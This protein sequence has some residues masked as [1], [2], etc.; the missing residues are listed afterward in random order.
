MKWTILALAVT[1]AISSEVLPS[2]VREGSSSRLIAE[3]FT[4]T[5]RS[6][7]SEARASWTLSD[8]VLQVDQNKLLVSL[9][10]P[11]GTRRVFFYMNLNKRF[12]RFGRARY[13]FALTCNA[14]KFCQGRGGP[15][16]QEGN[17]VYYGMKVVIRNRPLQQFIGRTWAPFLLS[18]TTTT[19]PTETPV[20][21][22]SAVL[23]TAPNGC[24]EVA[25]NTSYGYPTLGSGRRNP[26]R[27]FYIHTES[28]AS[29]WSPVVQELLDQWVGQGITLI[30]R[31]C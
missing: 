26:E 13:Q 20:L 18:T 28:K 19:R 16:L 9:Q 23:S 5:R 7:G 2:K 21:S 11:P 17:V 1:L 30:S 25:Y 10:G 15:V 3:D 31:S 27:G 4:N 14:A 8:P 24:A 12:S 22:C 6:P 29:S